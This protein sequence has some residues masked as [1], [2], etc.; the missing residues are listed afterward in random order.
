MGERKVTTACVQ[1]RERRKQF[2]LNVKNFNNHERRRSWRRSHFIYIEHSIWDRNK[3]GVDFGNLFITYSLFSVV[4][5]YKVDAVFR[6]VY[7]L[8]LI[9]SAHVWELF[10]ILS[11]NVDHV[12]I[13]GGNVDTL[14]V[15]PFVQGM[16]SFMTGWIPSRVFVGNT[17]RN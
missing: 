1:T 7:T 8:M 5:Y 15:G 14:V 13:R 10:A 3:T 17:R 12:R 16:Q 9:Y 6:H 2:Y 4:V 11:H